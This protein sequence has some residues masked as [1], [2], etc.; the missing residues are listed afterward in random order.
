MYRD[1]TVEVLSGAQDIGMGY[2]TLLRDIVAHQIGVP[3]ELI[4]VKVG[5]GDYPPG[6]ASGGS[7]TSR[8]TAPRA[9]HAA[10]M[11]RNAILKLIARE[12]DVSDIS[13]FVCNQGTIEYQ[14][15]HIA[16]SAACRLMNQ[17]RIAISTSDA[18][19]YWKNPTQSE[20]VQFADVRVD[21]ETGIVR[22]DKIVA[23]QNV[24]IPVNRRT[25]ENQIT[26][27]VIQ[28]LSYCLFEDRI[29]NRATGS[30][31]NANMDMY[32]IA[33][34]QD[35]P[36]IIPILWIADGER[37]V[38]SVGEPPVIPTAGAIATAVANAIGAQVRS[39]PI[40][41]DKVLRAVAGKE[42]A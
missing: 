32:K 3:Y 8:F 39:L 21:V 35:V 1:G 27:A 29:L 26:G 9:F 13:E 20:S 14:D 38:N 25:L 41:P 33:G 4:T 5:R 36:D 40:T 42:G 15:R 22:V 11:A 19:P 17:D 34:P 37:S 23:I 31:V 30:M 7:V 12:W 10:D 2:R 28:G 18:G 6:P 24:G 16:W